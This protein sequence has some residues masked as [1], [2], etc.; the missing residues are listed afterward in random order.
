MGMT[1]NFLLVVAREAA[2]K[3]NLEFLNIVVSRMLLCRMSHVAMFQ[4]V[5]AK[6]ES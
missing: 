5:G 4:L 3:R 1:D 6:D 2:V